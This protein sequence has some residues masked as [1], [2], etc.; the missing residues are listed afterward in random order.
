MGALKPALSEGTIFPITQLIPAQGHYEE[1]V[2]YLP[3]GLRGGHSQ[4]VCADTTAWNSA[5]GPPPETCLF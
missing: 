5:Q 2:Q 3:P 1:A 4:L